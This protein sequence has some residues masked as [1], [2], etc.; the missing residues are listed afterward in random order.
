MT[1]GSALKTATSHI[2]YIEDHADTRELVTFVL[3]GLSYRVTTSSNIEDALIMARTN[4]F[5]LFIL[6]SWLP[7]GSGIDLC[8]R[9]REFNQHTPIMFLSAAAYE[10]D[11]RAAI[12]SGAQAYLIK[13]AD[14]DLLGREVSRLIEVYRKATKGT[15][16]GPLIQP[17]GDR[18]KDRA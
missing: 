6:D 3:T 1:N 5:D 13:P 8:R 16:P 10:G 12:N 7:D 15:G 14:L 17:L 11:K 2:L 18:M 9:L 4:H